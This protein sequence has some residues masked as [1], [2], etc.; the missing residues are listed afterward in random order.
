[1]GAGVQ[2]NGE[3]GMHMRLLDQAIEATALSRWM[4]PAAII[5]AGFVY[6]TMAL[7]MR[8]AAGRIEH[9][10]STPVVRAIAP[11]SVESADS[12]GARSYSAGEVAKFRFGFLE[13]E[14][15]AD[16]SAE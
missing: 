6:L 14:D 16:A 10:R 1:M 7:H 15:D 4:L 12:S 8:G 13:F 2:F 3:Q 9:I 5:G 11:A